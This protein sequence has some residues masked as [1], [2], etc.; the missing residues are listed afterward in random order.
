[1][2]TEMNIY[3]FIYLFIALLILFLLKQKTTFIFLDSHGMDT[4]TIHK[5]TDSNDCILNDIFHNSSYV[6]ATILNF[7]QL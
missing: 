3:L 2:R 1:M 4:Y 6:W 5:I 7:L